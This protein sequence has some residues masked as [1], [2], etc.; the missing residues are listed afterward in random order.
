MELGIG[1]GKKL[2]DKRE[3]LKKKEADIKIARYLKK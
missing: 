2:F 3:D 1:R